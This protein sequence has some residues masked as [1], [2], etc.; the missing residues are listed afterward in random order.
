M[1]QTSLINKRVPTAVTVVAWLILIG[2]P[3]TVYSYHNQIT[4][5]WFLRSYSPPPQISQLATEAGMTTAGRNVFYRAGPQIVTE[6]AQMVSDCGLTDNQVAELGCYTSNE[7]IYL[8]SITEPALSNE[9]I[10][11]AAYEMLHPIYEQM[12]SGQRNTL[13][14][15]I[16]AAASTITDPNIL[17]QIQIYA[18]TEPGSR[19]EELYSIL[20][21]EWPTISPALAANYAQYLG[22]RA[23][24][25]TYHQQFEQT[26]DGLGTQI[27]SLAARI[28][29]TKEE[30][31]RYQAEGEIEQY[32]ALVP[33]VNGD[34]ALYN[35]EVTEYNRYGNDLFG[36]QSTTATQ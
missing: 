26:Y 24:L 32:N 14:S 36:T 5:W 31:A 9:M 6:R 8:L 11:T 33:S 28:T 15:E 17:D 34:V 2:G 13:N 1:N 7:H 3:L 21:T 27:S 25:V 23:Q 20:G 12:P 10:V 35:T 30:M 4:S 16:E 19:D 22:N 18:Q 29:A